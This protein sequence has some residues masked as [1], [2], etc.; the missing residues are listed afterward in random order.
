MVVRTWLEHDLV[1]VA[2]LAFVASCG[3]GEGAGAHHDS[4][5]VDVVHDGEGRWVLHR[6]ENHH[7]VEHVLRVVEV[8]C[9]RILNLHND[10]VQFRQRL[11]VK[12]DMVRSR[13]QLRPHRA[14]HCLQVPSLRE[15]YQVTRS[16]GWWSYPQTEYRTVNK[17]TYDFEDRYFVYVALT[18]AG[19][20][21]VVDKVPTPKDEEED[22]DMKQPDYSAVEYAWDKAD[23]TESWPEVRN[24]FVEYDNERSDD[25]KSPAAKSNSSE[26][27]QE[28]SSTNKKKYVERIDSLQYQAYSNRSE[29]SEN[30]YMRACKIKAVKARNIQLLEQGGVKKISAQVILKIDDVSDVGRIISHVENGIKELIDVKLIHYIDKGWVVEE[31]DK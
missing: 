8:P 7:Q 29:A 5:G 18:R 25:V 19:K 13:S 6:R 21:L 2:S 26:T 20:S 11:S 3:R 1:A 14:E 30:V 10:R 24:P 27:K 16:N 17:T 31:D 28:N 4:G 12:R 22:E 15:Q 9:P 23:L